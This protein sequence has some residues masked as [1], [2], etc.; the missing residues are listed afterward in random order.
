MDEVLLYPPL[1]HRSYKRVFVKKATLSKTPFYWQKMNSDWFESIFNGFLTL[2]YVKNPFLE[3]KKWVFLQYALSSSF[4]KL[5]P[6]SSESLL[7]VLIRFFIMTKNWQA[8]FFPP[9][10]RAKISI[11]WD[12]KQ[13]FRE[14]K[15]RAYWTSC[16]QVVLRY[17]GFQFEEKSA[18]SERFKNKGGAKFG[19]ENFWFHSH[20]MLIIAVAWFSCQ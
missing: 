14:G 20:S 13:K 8:D 15:W 4:L 16:L 6:K 5:L 19:W 2:F 3:H 9:I 10:F 17:L 1:L 12:H 11:F 7:R 18:G